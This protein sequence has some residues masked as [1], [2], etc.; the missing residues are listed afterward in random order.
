MRNPHRL[1]LWVAACFGLFL[2]SLLAACASAPVQEMSDAR[3][4]I[5]AAEQAGA[6]RLAPQ[7]IDDARQLLTNA[8]EQ[9]QNGRYFSARRNAIEAKAKA[10]EALETSDEKQPEKSEKSEKN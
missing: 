10:L 5:N 3:Q 6:E 9:L 4:A 7:A 2:A 8:E 1:P